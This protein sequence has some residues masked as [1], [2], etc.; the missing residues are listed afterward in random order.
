MEV[1]VIRLRTIHKGERVAIWERNGDVRLVDG[2]RRLWLRG[3]I[4]QP[5]PRHM[6]GP[7]EYLVIRFKDGHTSHVPGPAAVWFDPL[8]HEAITTEKAVPI[9]A[10]EAV[11]V[12]RR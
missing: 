1:H 9:D 10:N 11:V 5:L 8:E 12:Y 7:D 3:A 4:V 6:A 2:P